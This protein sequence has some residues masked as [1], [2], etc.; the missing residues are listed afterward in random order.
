[1]TNEEKH[2]CR[3]KIQYSLISKIIRNIQYRELRKID[4]RGKTVLEIGPGA[5]MDHYRYWNAKP[6]L[7]TVADIDYNYIKSISEECYKLGFNSR[8]VHSMI[9][10]EDWIDL[11]YM[12]KY[13]IVIA[14][15]LLE[16]VKN[17]DEKLYHLKEL[18]K[19]TFIGSIPAEG[20]LMWGL[21]RQLFATPKYRKMGI[22][23]KKEVYHQHVNCSRCIEAAF[24]R[25]W[26]EVKFKYWPFPFSRNLSV[27]AR[28]KHEVA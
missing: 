8:Y 23:W 19:E 1:M 3:K 17:I 9:I 16:H 6:K 11:Y 5:H 21:G 26:P 12:Q 18:T 28:I 15:N 10:Y 14:F 25:N 24:V 22:D 20:G 13:D 4:F 7:Y 2:N 27:I